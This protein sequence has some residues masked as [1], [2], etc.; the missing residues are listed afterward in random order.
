L[1]HGASNSTEKEVS[2]AMSKG[3]MVVAFFV[4][5]I[6]YYLLGSP[7]GGGPSDEPVSEPG[8]CEG[9]TDEASFTNCMENQ[10][11]GGDYP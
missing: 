3:M 1:A 4:I 10:Y 5:S 9:F 11:E 2:L 7:L 8:L 6:I